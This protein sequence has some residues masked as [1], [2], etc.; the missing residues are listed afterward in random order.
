MK[1]RRIGMSGTAKA[2]FEILGHGSMVRRPTTAQPFD[3]N[4]ALRDGMAH[5]R[6]GRPGKAKVLCRKVLNTHP[7]HPDALHLL[8]LVALHTGHPAPAAELIARAVTFDDRNAEFHANLGVA[9]VA[10]GRHDDGLA[11]FRRAIALQPG[12]AEAHYNVGLALLEKEDFTAA[13]AAF[14]ETLRHAP[15]TAD[16][17][18]NLGTALTKLGEGEAALR[19]FREAAAAAPANPRVGRNLGSALLESGAP[20]E[21]RRAFEKALEIA[22]GDAAAH[23]GLACALRAE[24]R[25]D[26]ALAHFRAAIDS[27]PDHGEAHNNLANL[28]RE[29]GRFADA[30]TH[31][32]RAVELRPNDKEIQINLA[33]VLV[34]GD[35]DEEAMRILDGLRTAYPGFAAV[36]EEIAALLQ[37]KGAYAKAR[38]VIDRLRALDPKSP[39]AFELLAND[40]SY[41]FSDHDMRQMEDLVGD[42]GV[43]PRVRA[44]LG[45]SVAQVFDRRG[46][47]DDAFRYL[48]RA[49]NLFDAELSYDAD[50]EGHFVKRT[51]AVFSPELFRDKAGIGADSDRP[52]F[53]VGMPRS[54]T[55]LVEQILASHPDAAGAGELLEIGLIGKDLEEQLPDAGAYPDCVPSLGGDLAHRLAA[56]YLERLAQVSANAARVSDKMP[57]NFKHLGLIALLF[58]G[59]RI[60]HCRRDPMDTCFSI[61]FQRFRTG[62]GYA[63]EFGKLAHYYRHYALLMEHWRRT[64]PLPMLELG[65]EDLVGDVETWARRL[66]AFCG[67]PW[68]E[69]C[70]GFH[71]SERPVRTASQWQVRQPVYGTAVGRWKNYETPLAPLKAALGP[72]KR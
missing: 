6:A 33:A 19:H 23:Y 7:D 28:L 14:R 10:S 54:G 41:T 31:Y 58:P 18:G 69:R 20:G 2:D 29:R 71:T 1:R 46:R 32:R 12:H 4:T 56:G 15:G 34:Q 30:E 50:K 13:A 61:Y 43:A 16:A 35:R 5:L 66:I 37:Q 27:D 21:A 59:A 44:R 3:V 26:E 45:F 57:A 48:R 72:I 22:P 42:D 53:I 65:Y 60:V 67:L 62:H 64:C 47:F 39:A 55:T 36:H 49:N 70:L 52:V 25:P 63:F 17:H 11:S 24:E 51:M 68:D 8:G 38:G 40:G 9:Q